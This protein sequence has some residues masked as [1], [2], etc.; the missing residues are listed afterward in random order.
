MIPSG[1]L[2]ANAWRMVDERSFQADE[3][4]DEMG[5]AERSLR[6]EDQVNSGSEVGSV[7]AHA[8][9][10]TRS[11]PPSRSAVFF[12]ESMWVLPNAS[13]SSACRL[14]IGRSWRVIWS[15]MNCT[16]GGTELAARA[17]IQKL[18]SR[19]ESTETR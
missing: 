8:F 6:G 18:A 10:T 3:D 5:A 7:S 9:P 17:A 15:L 4:V 12:E 19:V 11:N 1:K 16:H 14:A 13:T 2:L